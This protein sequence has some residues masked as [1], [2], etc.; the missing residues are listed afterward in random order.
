MLDYLAQIGM[1]WMNEKMT[2]HFNL[3]YL[4]NSWQCVGIG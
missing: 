2:A 3:V 4:Q 1:T